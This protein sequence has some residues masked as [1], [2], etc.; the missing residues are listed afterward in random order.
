MKH[1][2]NGLAYLHSQNVVHRDIK[3]AN[4]LVKSTTMGAEINNKLADFGL[5]RILAPDESTMSSNVGTLMFKAP[6][7]WDPKS[8]DK[9]KYHRNVDVYAAG[10]T[11]AAMLQAVPG[12]KHLNKKAFQ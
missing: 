9:V 6:E 11:F 3:P 12:R 4:I 1:V 2:M 10:L 7:F 5:C 8:N